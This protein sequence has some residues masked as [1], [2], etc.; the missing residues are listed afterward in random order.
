[1]N[2]PFSISAAQV[3]SLEIR[4]FPVD[5]VS[6]IFSVR[7]RELVFCGAQTFWPARLA[8][9]PSGSRGTKS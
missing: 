1:M 2:L 7:A 8:A 5:Q 9:D 3:R 6:T 4:R